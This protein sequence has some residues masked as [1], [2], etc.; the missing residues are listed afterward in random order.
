MKA[1]GEKKKAVLHR[2]RLKKAQSNIGPEALPGGKG[3]QVPL[4]GDT[5]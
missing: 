2:A 3:I 4:G 1:D 5:P